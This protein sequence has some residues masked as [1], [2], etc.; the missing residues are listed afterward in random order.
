MILSTN[1]RFPVYAIRQY[2]QIFEED[3]YKYIDTYKGRWILDFSLGTSDTVF[4]RRMELLARSS[5]LPYPLYPLKLRCKDWKEMLG[6]YV[7]KRSRFFIDANG[8]VFKLRGNKSKKRTYHIKVF[9]VV[10]IIQNTD[11]FFHVI[12]TDNG[13]LYGQDKV[14]NPF[15]ACIQIGEGIYSPLFGSAKPETSRKRFVL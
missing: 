14:A 6:A 2:L 13:I 7:L 1:V 10:E 9:P 15:F 8:V 12:Q 5:K 4:A 11:Y 3:G